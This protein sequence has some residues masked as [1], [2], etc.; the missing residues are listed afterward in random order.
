VHMAQNV[1][2]RVLRPLLVEFPSISAYW[3]TRY[4][5]DRAGSS[6]DCDITKIPANFENNGIFRSIRFRFWVSDDILQ[7]I[8]D[9]LLQL[10]TQN[11][12][13]ISDVRPYDDIGD[14]ANDRFLEGQLTQARQSTRRDLMKSFLHGASGLFIDMLEGPNADGNFLLA[15]N[16]NGQN[17]HGS[18]FESIHHLF[19]NLTDVT[20]TVFVPSLQPFTRMY[21]QQGIAMEEK[22]IR[23]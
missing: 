19:C 10:V 13:A 9:R 21:Q 15:K 8:D 1:A 3:F 16:N 2:G 22:R 5:E 18:T 7:P 20:T 11:G 12:F 14:L 4:G 17:P 23:F 6:G